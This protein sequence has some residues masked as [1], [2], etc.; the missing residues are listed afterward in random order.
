VV[1]YET[2]PE[3]MRPLFTTAGGWVIILAIILLESVGFFVIMKVI[4]I[5]V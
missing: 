5:D 1:F 4:K 3:F 2:D